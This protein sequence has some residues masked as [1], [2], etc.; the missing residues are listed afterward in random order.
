MFSI[1]KIAYFLSK[2]AIYFYS[3]IL[4]RYPIWN[5]TNNYIQ[6]NIRLLLITLLTICIVS[7]CGNNAKKNGTNN[8]INV[9]LNLPSQ[10]V[11][12]VKHAMGETKV[13]V[14]PQRVIVLGNLE[15]VLALGI[16]PVG[17][18]TLGDGE[19]LSYLRNQTEGIT[20]LGINGQPSLEKI[21]FLKPDLIL[22]WSWDEGIYEKLSQI[23]PTVFAEGSITWKEWLR[24]FAEALGKTP[25]A[26]KL[27]R[28][29]N[30]RVETFKE[31]MGD[32]FSQIQVSVVNFW[33]DKVRIYMKRSFSGLILNDIGMLRPSAQN[34]DKNSENL[35][36]ELIPKMEG[37]AIFLVLGEGKESKLNQFTNHPLW[38]QLNAVKQG[39]VY[40]VN[41]DAWIS[42]WGIIG[43]NR[44]LDDLFK[45]L[46]IEKSSK[47]KEFP[48]VAAL[49]Q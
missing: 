27:L 17:A 3:F 4:H 47:G 43:A 8:S 7:A 9:S 24:T 34:K 10:A 13:P 26:E 30:Q 36:L 49:T 35:S 31:Q 42:S 29:Y 18:T 16:K 11:R 38:F 23:A 39:K 48:K 33:A 28:N 22:G 44:V 20:K 14:N 15:N 37:D 41:S 25:E 2:I 40:Q 12:V 1:K 19:F 45:Y 6:R 32:R 21:L 46:V 5:L